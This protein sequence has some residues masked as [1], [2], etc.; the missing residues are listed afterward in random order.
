M[1]K[2]ILSLALVF[3]VTFAYSQLFNVGN[4]QISLFFLEFKQYKFSFSLSL[5]CKVQS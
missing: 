1:K 5:P 3:S 4:R 2:L